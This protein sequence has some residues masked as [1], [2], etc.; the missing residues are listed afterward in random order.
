[1]GKP[2]ELN[3]WLPLGAY[4]FLQAL[5]LLGAYALVVGSTTEE[6][7]WE[8]APPREYLDLLTDAG[9]GRTA[10]LWLLILTGLQCLFVLPVQL[11]V[12]TH[13]RGRSV[14]LSLAAAGAFLAILLVAFT[15][16]ACEL[17]VLYGLADDR[18]W[19]WPAIWIGLAVSWAFFTAL[20]VRYAS[21]SRLSNDDLLTRVARAIFAGT[22][23]ETAALIPIDVMIRRKTEC[24][25]WSGSF[26]ALVVSGAV[27]FVV[28]GP[29]VFLPLLAR[30]PRRSP[31]QLCQHCGYSRS[32]IA[33]DAPCPECGT[34]SGGA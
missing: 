22:V 6:G 17:V 5:L 27:G 26:W 7:G 9:Y 8:L 23:V 4:W 24:Y 21:R 13:R 29:A 34:T 11:Q 18:G 16:A 31:A 19:S 25:C 12:L 15:A 33:A 3:R 10:L 2:R 32:G 20:L 30:R 28:A 14:K 1:V